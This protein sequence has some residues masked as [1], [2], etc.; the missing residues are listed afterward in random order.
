MKQREYVDGS[1]AI[2]NFE[3][4]M[5]SLFKVPKDSIVKLLKKRKKSASSRKPKISDKD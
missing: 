3:E 2:E 5:K 1:K 4:G